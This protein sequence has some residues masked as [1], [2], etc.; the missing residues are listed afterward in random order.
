M[1][2]AYE[3]GLAKTLDQAG[4]DIVLVGDSLG[5]VF[6][7]YE[8]PLPVT[9]ED[10]IYHTQAVKRGISNAMVV[11]DLPF[12]SYQVSPEQARESAG[13]LV[14]EGGAEAVKAEINPAQMSHI[15]AII[16]MGIP[17]MAHI[18]FTP[19]SIHQLGGYK[20]Q[21]RSE[22]DALALIDLAHELADMGV[23]AVLLEMVPLKVSQTITKELGVPTIGIGAGPHCDGQVLVTQ[24]L[25]G[26]ESGFQPKFVKQYAELG[27]IMSGAISQFKNE[28]EKSKFPTERHSF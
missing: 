20:V 3:Y 2:T 24:D 22:K 28:V 6:C 17:V 7:G 12:L 8:N 27:K 16:D 18:G 23:F 21:G 15:Q 11:S 10:M 13:R 25:L 4:I 26:I 9:I 19:Q 14:K 5:N 1:L